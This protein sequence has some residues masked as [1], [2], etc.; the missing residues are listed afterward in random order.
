MRAVIDTRMTS[1]FS[2]QAALRN[3]TPVLIRVAAAADRD[4]FVAAF[5]KLEANSIYTRF[6]SARKSLSAAELDRLGAT[7]FVNGVTLAALV[8]S[9]PDETV[10][11]GASYVALPSGGSTRSA[12][13]AFTIEEDYQGQGLAS[14]L[15]STLVGIARQ[16]GI[17]RFEADVLAGNASMLKVFERSGL[18]LSKAR[19]GG[20]IHLVMD[21]RQDGDKP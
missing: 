14:K 20:V 4:K 11:G 6:F 5:E 18:P 2:Q 8:G 16:Y 12:E 13:V 19:D 1:R 9:A 15:L 7:D 21:L 17:G 3:G 10:I